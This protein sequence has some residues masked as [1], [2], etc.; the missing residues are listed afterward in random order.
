MYLWAKDWKCF[1]FGSEVSSICSAIMPMYYQEKRWLFGG[2]FG[3]GVVGKAQLKTPSWTITLYW[4]NINC[5]IWQLSAVCDVFI[6]V[7][8]SWL[9]CTLMEQTALRAHMVPILHPQSSHRDVLPYTFTFATQSPFCLLCYYFLH[10]G[11]NKVSFP[12]FLSDASEQFVILLE[13]KCLDY[14]SACLQWEPDEVAAPSSAL[15]G[16]PHPCKIALC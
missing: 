3:W 6:Y 12:R 5:S 13:V 8:A 11:N 9:C 1:G 4:A 15:N 14:S 10:R 7:P 16:H 2:R